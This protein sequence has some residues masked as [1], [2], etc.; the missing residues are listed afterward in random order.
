[1][2]DAHPDRGGTTEQFIDF[3]ISTGVDEATANATAEVYPDIP[4]QGLPAT[5][6]GRPEAYPWGLQWKRMVAFYG[7]LIFHAGRRMMAEADRGPGFFGYPDDAT[8]N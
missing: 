1:M 3:V 5:L 2:A 7:D 6:K 8:V 4:D